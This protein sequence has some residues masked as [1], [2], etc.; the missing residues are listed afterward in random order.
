MQALTATELDFPLLKRGKVRD[1][2]DV[3]DALLFVATDRISVYDVVLPTPIPGKGRILTQMSNY[4]FKA[5]SH[6]IPN[7][8]LETDF[9]S[10]PPGI[11][12]IPELEARSVLVKK[13][14]VLPIECVVRGYLAGSAWTEYQKTQAV[15]GIPLP[16]GL[17]ESQKLAQPLFTPATKAESGHDQNIPFE[18]AAELVGDSLAEQVRA[19]SLHL[20]SFAE[21]HAA[22]KG[23]IIAD[24]KFEFGI[25]DG[26]LILVDELLTPDSSRFWPASEYAPG[27]GQK[28][29]DKQFV[30]DYA[31]QTGWNKQP[32]GPVLPPEIVEGTRKKYAEAFVR[33]T[34]ESP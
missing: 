15:C 6:I 18:R 12:R 28:S 10:F 25:V 27:S 24:T 31:A 29:F 32:P 7:H 8:L 34:G 4:W 9:P 20:Y 1:V 33:L 22:S 2:Y 13:A 17:V 14:Q 5:T 3:G 11:S 30:R 21:K 19:A 26:T 23:I 16:E